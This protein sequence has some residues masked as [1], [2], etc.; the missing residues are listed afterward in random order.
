[1]ESLLYPHLTK[2]LLTRNPSLQALKILSQAP[3][4]HEEEETIVLSKTTQKFPKTT[5]QKPPTKEV[6]AYADMWHLS[7]TPSGPLKR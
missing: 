2:L 7:P 3:N 6:H 4:H 1:M 5:F